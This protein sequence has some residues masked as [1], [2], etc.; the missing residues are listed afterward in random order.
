LYGKDIIIAFLSGEGEV[1]IMGEETEEEKIIQKEKFRIPFACPK[2][3]TPYDIRVN[4]EIRK[5]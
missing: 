1:H 3:D 2:C 5:F 4:L